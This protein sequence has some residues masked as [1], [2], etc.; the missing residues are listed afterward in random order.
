MI[1]VRIID[2]YLI[3]EFIGPF[4]LAVGGFVIVG[5]VDILFTLV[6][7]F[8]NAG[9]S[10]FIVARLLI[11]KIPAIIVLFFPMAVLFSIML[12]LVRVAKDNEFTV[13]RSSGVKTWRILAPLVVVVFFVGFFCFYINETIVPWANYVSDNL[14]RQVVRKT[15]PPDISENVFFKDDKARYFYIKK[16]DAAKAVMRNVMIYELVG[17]FPRIITAKLAK[18]NQ[19]S[20][21]L[22]DGIVYEFDKEGRAEFTSSFSRMN[23]HLKKDLSAFY[24][25]SKSAKEMDSS[26]LA[27]KI[28]VLAK[29]GVG[30]RKLEVEYHMKKAMPAACVIFG[31]VGMAYC[32]KLVR[33]GKDLWG[34]VFAICL[35]VLSVGFWFFLVALFRSFGRGGIIAP[36]WAAWL[37]NIFYF[38]VA[39]FTI[40][41]ESVYK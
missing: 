35:A 6:D 26:A 40:V 29:G 14:I 20:W 36:F 28:K 13:L 15:P 32:L 5:L 30:T 8:V 38:L 33:S 7:L 2:R 39:S 37:P 34:V 24:R 18:W 17:D 31:L 27:S 21:F 10:G 23:L 11:Y 3:G 9:V 19:R 16:I 25:R 1:K 4:L 12:L 22:F 41:Y